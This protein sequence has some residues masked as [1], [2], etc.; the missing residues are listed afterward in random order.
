MNS[1]KRLLGTTAIS[2]G[3]N[4]IMGIYKIGLAI[5]TNSVLIFIYSFYNFGTMILK[6]TFIKNYKKES[7]KYYLV[8]LIVVITSICYMFYSVK[9]IRGELNPNYHEYLAIGIAAVTFWD[10]GMAIF[11]SK[12]INDQYFYNGMMG[13]GIALIAMCIGIYMIFY[14]K[15]NL[16]KEKYYL[17]SEKI[18]NEGSNL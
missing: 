6:A 2:V 14:I 8:G 10:I 11:S 18:E 1:E 16:K 7:E 4:F 15:K 9:M 5:F 13:I 3:V 12:G 17:E